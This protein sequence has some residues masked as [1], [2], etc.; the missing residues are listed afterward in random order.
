MRP[1]AASTCCSNCSRNTCLNSSRYHNSQVSL[2]R[3]FVCERFSCTKIVRS[4]VCRSG[5][6]SYYMWFAFHSLLEG[7]HRKSVPKYR[8]RRQNS[9]LFH[10]KEYFLEQISCS[11]H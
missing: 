2:Y 3:V 4:R 8:R 7:L 9:H 11:F 10:T 1:S 6:H 5:I